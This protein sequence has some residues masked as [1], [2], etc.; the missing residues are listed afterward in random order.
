MKISKK[1]IGL[2]LGVFGLLLAVIAYSLVFT[3]YQDKIASLESELTS[4]EAEKTE[5]ETLAASQD[6]YELE[7][8]RLTEE[9]DEILDQFPAGI[10]PE[11]EIMYVVELE[12][13]VDIDIPSI[14]YGSPV[15][16][17]G[18]AATAEEATEGET[19][20]GETTQSETTTVQQGM[21]AY[22]LAMN[23]S[24]S[25]SYKGLKDA[26]TYTN[27]HL[28]RMV[29]DT[30]SVSYDATTGK[31]S[32]SMT[33]NLYYLTGTDKVYTQPNVPEG[34]LGVNN[35]FGTIE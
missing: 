29:I 15:A 12:K 2:L 26:I 30:L 1:E 19:T 21:A 35:I 13:E 8:E 33:F 9:N 6:Y 17:Y 3:P 20:E 31:T 25:T 18:A 34:E 7:I 32:G 14:S 23:V 28:N 10:E 4:L 27:A 22:Q 24:Y 11:D 16:I 5:L